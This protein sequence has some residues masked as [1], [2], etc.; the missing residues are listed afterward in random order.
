[1]MTMASL[2]MKWYVNRIKRGSLCSV[3]GVFV[4][5][6]LTEK[7]RLILPALAAEVIPSCSKLDFMSS[8]Q[9][10]FLY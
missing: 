8:R 10:P 3:I 1:M 4:G 5:P 9:G 2:L 6:A 7:A